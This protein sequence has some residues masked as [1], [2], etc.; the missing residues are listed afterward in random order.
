MVLSHGVLIVLLPLPGRPFSASGKVENPRRKGIV[1]ASA[2]EL[3]TS[4]L[5]IDSDA[6]AECVASRG[7]LARIETDFEGGREAGVTATPTAI[8]NR[9]LV[10]GV[11][12]ILKGLRN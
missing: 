8:I 6:F 12:A 1:V 4:V 11:A 3:A 10:V 2:D 7:T 5:G 9:R